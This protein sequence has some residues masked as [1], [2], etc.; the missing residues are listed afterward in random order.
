MADFEARRPPAALDAPLARLDGARD[1]LTKAWL[2]RVVERAPL[3]EIERMPTDQIVRELPGLISQILAAV[4]QQAL[5]GAGAAQ[6][7]AAGGMA[8]RLVELRGGDD[9]AAAAVARDA[10][11]LHSVLIEALERELRDLDREVFA[12]AVQHLATVFGAL[13]AAAVEQLVERRS[14]ELETLANTDALTGLFNLRYMQQQIRQLI[15]AHNRYGHPFALLLLDVDGLKR[16]NDSYGHSAG[17]QALVGVA[18]AIREVV[19]TVD[20]PCRLGGDEFCVLAPQQTASRGKALAERVADAVE[21]LE[22]PGGRIG[23]SIGVV[24]CPQ[25]AAERQRLLELADIA[26]YQAKAAG[27]RVAIGSAAIAAQ[28]EEGRRGGWERPH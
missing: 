10:G 7:I 20:T 8:G 4:R 22:A 26:M 16:I 21:R 23:V 12:A 6:P 1:Q 25:H 24:S 18:N 27:E 14:R 2:L 11:A 15:G 19:R 28:A 17:D 9:R 5:A 3:A 13:Q